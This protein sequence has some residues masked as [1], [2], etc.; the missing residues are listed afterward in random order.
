MDAKSFIMHKSDTSTDYQQPDWRRCPKC[1]ELLEN[2]HCY[3]IRDDIEE[4]KKYWLNVKSL[5]TTYKHQPSVLL[6][7]KTINGGRRQ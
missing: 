6:I 4:R 5:I 2:C 3:E 1:D 7:R